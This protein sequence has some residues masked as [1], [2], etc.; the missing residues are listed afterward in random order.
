[1]AFIH[2]IGAFTLYW[3][4]SHSAAE[5]A[6]TV[7]SRFGKY[8]SLGVAQ[9][10]EEICHK[11]SETNIAIIKLPSLKLHAS[12]EVQASLHQGRS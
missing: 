4:F 6:Y 7:I 8:L 5:S 2:R 12:Y 1:M 11:F 3:G 10:I 9:I